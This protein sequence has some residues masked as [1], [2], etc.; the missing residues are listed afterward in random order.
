[1]ETKINFLNLHR[2]AYIISGIIIVAGLISLFTLGLNKGIDFSGGRNYIARFDKPV[3]TVEMTEALKAEFNDGHSNVSVITIG[4]S[5]QV[6]ISTNYKIEESSVTE[7]GDKDA[8]EL[9]IRG[10]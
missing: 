1:M 7:N 9:E 2:K 4:S 6:R 8:V 10:K 5:N 3:N